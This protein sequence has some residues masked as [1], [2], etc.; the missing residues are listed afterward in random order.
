MTTRVRGGPAA[1]TCHLHQTGLN[2]DPSATLF[3]IMF[4]VACQH[5]GRTPYLLRA[6]MKE[7]VKYCHDLY[8]VNKKHFTLMGQAN[9]D[10]I[11][12]DNGY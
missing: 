3:Y 11:T 6:D 5:K 12:W 8:N 1:I 2:A 4:I 10:S 7:V 9:E